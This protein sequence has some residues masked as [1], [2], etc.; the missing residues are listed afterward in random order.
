MNY[1]LIIVLLIFKL[2]YFLNL[3]VHYLILKIKPYLL[4]LNLYIYY[5]LFIAIIIFIIIIKFS[6]NKMIKIIKNT[7]KNIQLIKLQ[8]I[9][10]S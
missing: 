10:Q 7:T 6:K 9:W 4:S 2:K 5:L 1:D 8:K 3:Y